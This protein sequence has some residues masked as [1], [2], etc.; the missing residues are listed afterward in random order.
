MQPRV[1]RGLVVLVPLLLVAA[2]AWAQGTPERLTLEDLLKRIAEQRYNACAQGLKAL[3]CRVTW[4]GEADGLP[5]PLRREGLAAVRLLF[6]A[7]R[8]YRAQLLDEAGKPL[9]L[10]PVEQRAA[11]LLVLNVVWAW[12]TLPPPGGSPQDLAVAE[13]ARARDFRWAV[14][15]GL[16]VAEYLI[17]AIDRRRP[18]ARCTLTL[19]ADLLLREQR[20][21]YERS[22][23]GGVSLEHVTTYRVVDGK[24][25]FPEM[26]SSITAGKGAMERSFTYK[27]VSGLWMLTQMTTRHKQGE[28]EANLV[29]QLDY[30]DFKINQPLAADAFVLPPRPSVPRDF[31]SPQKTIETLYS[32][33]SVGDLD[34]MIA[35][36]AGE[37]GEAFARDLEKQ[38]QAWEPDLATPSGRDIWAYFFAANCG[39]VKRLIFGA[40]SSSGGRVSLHVKGE[41]S[42]RPIDRTFKL[43]REGREWKIAESADEVYRGYD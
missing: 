18:P 38:S 2:M 12:T 30:T 31:S 34:T 19:D 37:K 22:L 11:E 14:K 32:A 27:K 25:T 21:V 26:M 42:G 7:P 3:A 23:G 8:K 43:V 4:R 9:T 10:V 6:E 15:D 13:A 1:R 41:T 36:F 39:T 33:T 17:P 29:Y 28:G 40:R 16:V 5:G 24:Y 35:C 20:M